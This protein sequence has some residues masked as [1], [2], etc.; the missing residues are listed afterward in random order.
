MDVENFIINFIKMNC[1]LHLQGKTEYG[2][3]V[4]PIRWYLSTKV[5]S[6][7]PDVQYVDGHGCKNRKSHR[8]HLRVK[9][10]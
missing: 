7:I 10:L 1:C 6:N 5:H 2:E 9:F 4:P 8:V 3:Q